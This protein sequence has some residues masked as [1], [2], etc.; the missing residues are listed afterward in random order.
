MKFTIEQRNI[1]KPLQQVCGVA[2]S[3]IKLPILSNL[4][5]KAEDNKMSITC[6]DLEA[7]L[8]ASLALSGEVEPGG[9]TIPARKFLNIC[10]SLPQNARILVSLEMGRLCIHANRSYFSLSTLP[11]SEF[12]SLE[13]WQSDISFFLSDH[14]SF[15]N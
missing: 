3:K 5:L 9:V 10:R 7:E 12:P 1:I 11:S 15:L 8:T 13:N 6:T 14:F 4:L 2:G